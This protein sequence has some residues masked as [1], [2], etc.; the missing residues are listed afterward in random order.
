MKKNSL[1][2]S[3]FTILFIAEASAQTVAVEQAVSDL[4]ELLINPTEAGLKAISHPKLTYGHSSGRME[5]QT[6]FVEALVSGRSDF[7]TITLKNQQIEIIGKTAW[8]RHELEADIVDG[9]NP[10]S[11]KL[12]VLLIWVKEKNGWKLLARQ[13]V[14]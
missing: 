14:K 11:I 1:L 13:A 6:E 12:K 3:I 5:N 2:L 8:V 4:K 7:K 10:A 9:G